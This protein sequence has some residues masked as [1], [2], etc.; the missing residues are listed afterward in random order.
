MRCSLRRREL[1]KPHQGGIPVKSRLWTNAARRRV[2]T[3]HGGT[4]EAHRI[5]EG[6]FARAAGLE[7]G[8]LTTRAVNELYPRRRGS[9]SAAA[10]LRMT[11]LRRPAGP[12]GGRHCEQRLGKGAAR[13]PGPAALQDAHQTRAR[14]YHQPTRLITA[15]EI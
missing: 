2:P 7:Q 8:F 14:W 10:D 6:T 4:S 11:S 9:C 15:N 3:P 1:F 12:P 13:P 5:I